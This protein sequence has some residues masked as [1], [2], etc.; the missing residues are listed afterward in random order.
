MLRAS[1]AGEFSAMGSTYPIP[2]QVR[3][4][5]YLATDGQTLFG[6][7]NFK[8]FDLLDVGVYRK[9]VG[10]DVFTRQNGLPG[11]V[12]T[13][14]AAAPAAP[15]VTFTPGLTAGEEVRVQGERLHERQF[16]VTRAGVIASASLEDEL[17]KQTV[18]L[19]ELRR[20][21]NEF[22]GLEDLL[23]EVLEAIEDAAVGIPADDSVTNQKLRDSVG[24][25]VIGR[26]VN[27]TGD[28]ADIVAATDGD[29]LQRVGT[30]LKFAPPVS[31]AVSSTLFAARAIVAAATIPAPVLAINTAGYY[32]AGDGG[33]ALYK[34]V[35]AD[36]GHA[37]KVQSADGAWWEIAPDTIGVNFRQFGAKGDSVTDDRAACQSCIDFAQ[38]RNLTII[39]PD[40]GFALGEVTTPLNYCLK[41]N[42]WSH[43]RGVGIGSRLIPMA[44]VSATTSCIWLEP[45]GGVSLFECGDFQIVG[46]HGGAVQRQGEHGILIDTR[47]TG[48]TLQKPILENL[49]IGQGYHDAT[50]PTLPRAG[51]AIFHYNDQSKNPEGGM[52]GGLIRD[53]RG[54]GGG[55]RLYQTGD[56][57]IIQNCIMYGENNDTIGYKS[58]GVWVETCTSDGGA[59]FFTMENLTIVNKGGGFQ[60]D[61]A[62]NFEAEGV[63]CECFGA[64]VGLPYTRTVD[65]SAGRALA[66]VN[67][68][69]T[70]IGSGYIQ[71]CRFAPQGGVSTLLTSNLYIGNAQNIVVEDDNSFYAAKPGAFA[72]ELDTNSFRCKVGDIKTIDYS[73]AG[74]RIVDNGTFNAYNQV[75][76][77]TPLSGFANVPGFAELQARRNDSGSVKLAGRL[78]HAGA[79]SGTIFATLQ[80]R[81][82]PP[83]NQTFP[84]YAVAGAVIPAGVTVGA[85]GNCTYYGATVTQ[86]DVSS[87]EFMAA[88]ALISLVAE[89]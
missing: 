21:C 47:T 37:G 19:Q 79:G 22:G 38:P 3:R 30:Q 86:L 72:V 1:F 6:P 46:G 26:A 65:G 53:C 67:S 28:P 44:G 23:E 56:Q 54:L 11:V 41:L 61:Y 62:V 17:D 83:E 5:E 33:Q 25:S 12:I 31:G 88:P 49:N 60:I 69:G 7:A 66:I 87:I 27:S 8:A 80:A 2:R 35:G 64:G 70:T 74:F 55:V 89:Q 43:V 20:D 57:N 71:G 68:L 16:D 84:I 32:V 85:D 81:W 34:R 14:A 10:A 50:S 42:G 58:R 45:Q 40:G 73:G 24:L 78:G 48:N 29:V 75:L 82:R 63:Y 4:T 36:P 77:V 13:L 18:I 76:I 51:H 15:S 39:I 59:G 9:A 52:F